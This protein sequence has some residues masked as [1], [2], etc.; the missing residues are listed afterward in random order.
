MIEIKC[1]KRQKKIIQESLLN[2]EG[3]L[4]PQRQLTCIYDPNA[5]CKKCFEKKIKWTHPEKRRVD[6]AKNA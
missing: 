2:P 6:R 5:D 3:C 1:S 4:W